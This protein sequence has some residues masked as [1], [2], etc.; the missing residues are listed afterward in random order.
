MKLRAMVCIITKHCEYYSDCSNK[1]AKCPYFS[2]WAIHTYIY[3]IFYS[4]NEAVAAVPHVFST[5]S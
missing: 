2:D 5:V 3:I 1:T 4:V